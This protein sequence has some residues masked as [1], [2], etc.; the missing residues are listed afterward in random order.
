[1]HIGFRLKTAV[2][3]RELGAGK[4]PSSPPK[5]KADA[6]NAHDTPSTGRGRLSP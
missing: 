5:V 1:M 3:Q 2:E 4:G 6:S